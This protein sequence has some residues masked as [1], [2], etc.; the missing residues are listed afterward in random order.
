MLS[1]ASRI[2]IRPCWPIKINIKFWFFF[3]SFRDFRVAVTPRTRNRR[4]PTQSRNPCSC[5][6]CLLFPNSFCLSLVEMEAPFKASLSVILLCQLT[7][8]CIPP[9]NTDCK[10]KR[11]RAQTPR[12]IYPLLDLRAVEI[13]AQ[14]KM[15]FCCRA[16]LLSSSPYPPLCIP[17]SAC[18]SSVVMS[19][20]LQRH[21][22][23]C[24]CWGTKVA[25]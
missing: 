1:S 12:I 17:L 3:T 8:S 21:L 23:M 10:K 2:Y 13:D 7:P 5:L 9:I 6:C 18:C 15:S 4:T 11:E 24:F 22:Q 14:G 19:L 16:S 25:S 20:R